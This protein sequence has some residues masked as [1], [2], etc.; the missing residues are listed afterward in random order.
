M[1]AEHDALADRFASH[2]CTDDQQVDMGI[3]RNSALTT[4]RLVTQLTKPCRETSLALTKLEEAVFWA[5]AAIAR[6]PT[7]ASE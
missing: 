7:H 1:K 5:N 3:V 2:A 4:G 6:N